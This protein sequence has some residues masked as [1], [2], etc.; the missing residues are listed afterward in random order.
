MA[1]IALAAFEDEDAGA[2]ELN[3][4]F[5]DIGMDSDDGQQDM[6]SGDEN[7]HVDMPEEEGAGSEDEGSDGDVVVTPPLHRRAYPHPR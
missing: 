1:T 3:Q 4:M 5:H 2:E 6:G 7:E